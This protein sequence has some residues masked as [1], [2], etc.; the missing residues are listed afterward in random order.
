M[1][2][3]KLS[4]ALGCALIASSAMAE[5]NVT[6]DYQAAPQLDDDADTFGRPFLLTDEGIAFRKGLL[7]SGP[8]EFTNYVTQV[9]NIESVEQAATVIA[10]SGLFEGAP[11]STEDFVSVFENYP[12][13]P[14]SESAEN[15]LAAF[16]MTVPVDPAEF[17]R[18]AQFVLHF[19]VSN[20]PFESEFPA[21]ETPISGVQG[22]EMVGQSQSYYY[23]N[24]WVGDGN[25]SNIVKCDISTFDPSSELLLQ[26]AGTCETILTDITHRGVDSSMEIANYYD[27]V[28]VRDRAG[29]EPYRVILPN[30]TQTSF[31]TALSEEYLSEASESFFYQLSVNQGVKPIVYES[32]APFINLAEGLSLSSEGPNLFAD[33]SFLFAVNDSIFYIHEDGFA[34]QIRFDSTDRY[35][36]EINDEL[37]LTTRVEDVDGIPVFTREICSYTLTTAYTGGQETSQGDLGGTIACDEVVATKPINHV[38]ALG[39]DT[40]V[41]IGAVYPLISDLSDGSLTFSIPTY[42]ESVSTG[43]QQFLAQAERDLRERQGL[44][45]Y[46]TPE[47]LR[48]NF[49]AVYA[50]SVEENSEVVDGL[51]ENYPLP[52]ND[53]GIY[54]FNPSISETDFVAIIEQAENLAMEVNSIFSG[55]DFDFSEDSFAPV[56]GEDVFQAIGPAY[57]RNSFRFLSPTSFM[58]GEARYTFSNITTT[59]LT[60]SAVLGGDVAANGA[61]VSLLDA[62][63]NLLTTSTVDGEF[64]FEGLEVGDYTL[65]I[66]YPNHVFECAAVTIDEN[67]G[68]ELALTPS[69]LLGGDFN[70]DGQ[71]S[72]ID[73]WRFWFRIFYPGVSY[74]INNDGAV[75]GADQSLLQSN[76][77]AVQCQL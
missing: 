31:T 20:K 55:L 18:F 63:G 45:Q 37:M 67:T 26:P 53:P 48:E 39:Y 65:N 33:V 10:N 23:F 52:P 73:L 46:Y 24:Q 54:G 50:A 71:I 34:E 19:A 68:A 8:D 1:K 17:A 15:V 51:M 38:I 22:E 29:A 44:G 72:G 74:D 69:E 47:L 59:T 42:I 60:G 57:S 5:L 6:L 2:L 11:F 28:A 77:G 62:E 16:E 36:R 76:R 7:Y 30:G 32:H 40:D 43:E 41:F 75:N 56:F 58:S 49:L 66:E 12:E 14:T 4:V 13:V 70:N 27:L 21:A 61:T 64:A 35:V 9:T 3:T 25:E